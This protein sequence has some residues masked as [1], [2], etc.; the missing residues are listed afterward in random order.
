MILGVTGGIATG[1]STVTRALAELG[2]AVVSADEVARDV[3]R[4]GPVLEQLVKRFGT[5]ILLPDGTLDR[6]TLGDIVFADAAA[7][8]D[9]NGIMHPAIIAEVERRLAELTRRQVPLIVYEAP[10]LFEAGGEKRVDAVLVVLADPPGQLARLV[11]RDGRGEADAR[12]RIAAQL[13]LADKVARADYL[14]DNSGS[15]E[16]TS[17]QVNALYRHLLDLSQNAPPAPPKTAE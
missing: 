10:L 9:L 7:R 3:V 8:A 12:A 13:P 17:A 5:R 4:P 15:P 14:I 6:R 11:A 16:E 1:K 2:A